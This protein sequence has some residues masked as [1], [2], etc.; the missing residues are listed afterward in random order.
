MSLKE[1]LFLTCYISRFDAVF[2]DQNFTEHM[3]TVLLEV[4]NGID[5]KFDTC[6]KSGIKTRRN[7]LLYIIELKK[8]FNAHW[9]KINHILMRGN[10]GEH[11]QG[12]VSLQ[13][14]SKLFFSPFK[15]HVQ[16]LLISTKNFLRRE[17]NHSL[18][19]AGC[20]VWRAR[21]GNSYWGDRYWPCLLKRH[22]R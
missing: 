14:L 13:E 4:F 20:E 11:A 2:S 7:P 3:L 15:S 6:I 5:P 19:S 9:N 21:E 17:K 18:T 16:F 22:F 12:D 8:E 10:Q 1:A